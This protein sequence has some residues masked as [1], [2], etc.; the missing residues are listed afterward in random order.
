[1]DVSD[2]TRGKM[3]AALGAVADAQLGEGAWYVD[4]LQ[5]SIPDHMHMHA[6]RLP[7]WA[8]GKPRPRL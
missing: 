4:A 7:P 6:R 8:T 1:M 5:R 2:E 3:L